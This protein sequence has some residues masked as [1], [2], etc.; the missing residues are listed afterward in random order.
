M[1]NLTNPNLKLKDPAFMDALP[2]LLPPDAASQ[3]RMVIIVE[4]MKT[5][6]QP[7]AA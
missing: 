2:G 6:T 7:A 3:A 4:R 5:V 1:P